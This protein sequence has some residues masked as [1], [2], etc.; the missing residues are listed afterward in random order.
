M[1][2]QPKGFMIFSLSLFF[3]LT[4]SMVSSSFGEGGY[5]G[6]EGVY[7]EDDQTIS[8]STKELSIEKIVLTIDNDLLWI[9][10]ITIYVTNPGT[11]D[12]QSN[13]FDYKI[14][15]PELN[16]EYQYQ[17]SFFSALGDFFKKFLG[18]YKPPVRA[19]EEAMFDSE[20][21]N[22]GLVLEYG[23]EYTILVELDPNNKLNE[24]DE[25][26]NILEK[27]I[28]FGKNEPDYAV[29]DIS[30]AQG[31]NGLNFYITFSNDGDLE[32]QSFPYTFVI[33][34]LVQPTKKEDC[35]CADCNIDGICDNTKGVCEIKKENI[36]T[37]CN[38]D[39]ICDTEKIIF[40]EIF[41]FEDTIKPS[42][43]GAK[44]EIIE[45]I[46]TNLI[47]CVPNICP[48]NSLNYL[49]DG[50][51]FVKVNIGTYDGTISP[52]YSE[53]IKKIEEAK[54]S[55]EYQY[56]EGGAGEPLFFVDG[57]LDNNGLIKELGISEG[58]YDV[59]R[60]SDLDSFKKVMLLEMRDLLREGK[61]REAEKF[62]RESIEEMEKYLSKISS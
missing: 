44:E 27:K 60:S 21:K 16:F 14:T 13:E 8:D 20:H 45:N 46:T 52:Q 58:H 55:G 19:G 26:N 41:K 40:N 15:I 4:L 12:I 51:Y 61:V 47:P 34:K 57:N 6:N 56:Q 1:K 35:I 43:I 18:M 33:S 39:G 3:I 30:G 54:L 17:R 9:E 29:E 38:K 32:G 59:L 31:N 24:I 23:K 28:S 2:I 53:T 7:Q 42:T 37:D 48:P 5:Y 10:D 49:P 22:D 11:E 36:C 25:T 50:V 62:E